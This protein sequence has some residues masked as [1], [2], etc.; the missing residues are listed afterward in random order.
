M[1]YISKEEVK[2][3]RVKIRKEFPDYK[4]SVTCVNYSKISVKILSGPIDLISPEYCWSNDGYETVNYFYIEDHYKNFP[5]KC[6]M[7]KRIYEIINENNGE[8]V[9]DGDYGSVPNFYVDIQI[10]NWDKPYVVKS[11]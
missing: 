3:K 4:I 11:K 7:L 1:P 5:E 9:Y 10:G 6:K 8:L 2:S